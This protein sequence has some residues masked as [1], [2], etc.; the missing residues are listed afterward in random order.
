MSLWRG[1]IL[2]HAGEQASGLY[3]MTSGQ[4]RYAWTSA[5]GQLEMNYVKE[6]LWLAEAALWVS[7]VHVGRLQALQECNVFHLDASKFRELV[8][9][10]PTQLPYLKQFARR[11]LERLA[12]GSQDNTDVEANL[13][14]SASD[15]SKF[16]S[17][18]PERDSSSF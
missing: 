5:A 16:G 12:D 1:D 11:V 14:R 18:G 8:K 17:T 7:W 13:G 3:R 9:F 6:K 15:N 4:A 2:F 10:Y